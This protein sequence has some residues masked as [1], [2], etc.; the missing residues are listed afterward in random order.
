[1]NQK[2]ASR[3]AAQACMKLAAAVASCPTRTHRQCTMSND[4]SRRGSLG[5]QLSTTILMRIRVILI[6]P[7]LFTRLAWWLLQFEFLPGFLGRYLQPAE[8][9][10][11]KNSSSISLRP[12]KPIQATFRYG[13]SA[14]GRALPLAS[15]LGI[16][17]AP[18]RSTNACEDT[19]QRVKVT[20]SFPRLGLA[21]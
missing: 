19:N 17:S 5:K 7:G 11:V 9:V 1:L 3:L 18:Y 4:S 14:Q 13:E 10:M 20:L 15:S 16:A 6:K 12:S 2:S 8:F 21:A